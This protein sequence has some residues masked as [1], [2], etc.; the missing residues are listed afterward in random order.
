MARPPGQLRPPAAQ[1]STACPGA[2]VVK[3]V[4]MISVSVAQH[5]PLALVVPV[6]EPSHR[7][8]LVPV[9]LDSL[10]LVL[11]HLRIRGARSAVPASM[12]FQAR[13]I[14]HSLWRDHPRRRR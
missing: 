13:A 14:A 7:R 2:L 8:D 5:L 10:E 6:R 9:L 1:R 11:V 3:A 12:T 4:H